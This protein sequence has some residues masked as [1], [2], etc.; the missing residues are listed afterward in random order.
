MT[1][2]SISE[3]IRRYCAAADISASTLCVRALQNSRFMDRRERKLEKLAENEAALRKYMRENPP[4]K[5][6][7]A[8]GG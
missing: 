6:D 8:T 4:V 5:T 7:A 3:E 2:T 1:D